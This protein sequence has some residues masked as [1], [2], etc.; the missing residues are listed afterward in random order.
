MQQRAASAVTL[1]PGTAGWPD[2]VP[3]AARCGQQRVLARSAVLVLGPAGSPT[4]SARA[5]A[6]AQLSLWGRSRLADDMAAVI[7]ELVANAVTASAPAGTPVRFGMKLTDSSIVA[8]VF[9]CAPGEPV[10]VS[11]TP[12]AESGRGLCIVAA[13][14]SRWGWTLLRGC[15]VVW[16]EVPA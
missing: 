5:S 4:R 2:A 16:A 13:L 3:A 1:V 8:E 15:K 14:S 9:D 6:G 7:A 10:P 12:D 11:A